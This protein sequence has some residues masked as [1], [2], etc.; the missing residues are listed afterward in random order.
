MELANPGYIDYFV[1]QQ[2]V[3][4]VLGVT[5]EYVARHPEPVYYYIPV[6]IGAMLPWSLTL[7]QSIYAALKH[8]EARVAHADIFLVAF[9]IGSLLVMSAATSKLATYLLPL[10]PVAAVLI[11]RYWDRLFDARDGRR[12]VSQIIAFGSLSLILVAFTVHTIGNQPFAHWDVRTGVAH[13]HFEWFLLGF[14]VLWLVAS[15]FAVLAKPRGSFATLSLTTP[16]MIGFI[17]W[18]LCP[19]AD[20]YRGSMAIAAM[21]DERLAPQ[22]PLYV[23]GRLLDSAMFYTNRDA[24]RLESEDALAEYMARDERVFVLV[25]SRTGRFDD[26]PRDEYHVLATVANKSIISNQAEK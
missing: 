5:G 25:R 18:V 3:G 13:D 7:P 15:V 24:V 23:Y 12:N 6:L 9:F 4:N 16:F 14:S 17:L 22:A 8:R 20:D 21:I 1:I 10:L 19:R 11:G 26:S 2:H